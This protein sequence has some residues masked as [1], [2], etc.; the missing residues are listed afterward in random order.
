MLHKRLGFGAAPMN[1]HASTK[2]N[3]AI[4]ACLDE[5]LASES[6]FICLAGFIKRL[7]GDES[8]THD[9]VQEVQVR[10][11]RILTRLAAGDSTSDALGAG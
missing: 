2:I 5:C 4:R 3:A 11:V 1:H 8:W 10:T 9:E 7:C 6:P